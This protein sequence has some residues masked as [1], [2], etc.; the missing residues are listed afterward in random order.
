[1]LQLPSQQVRSKCIISL[2]NFA[3]FIQTQ[4]HSNQ[5]AIQLKAGDLKCYS[6]VYGR[7]NNG[8]LM[9]SITQS[10]EPMKMLSYT[11]KENSGYRRSQDL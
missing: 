6:L 5:V 2:E 10:P 11:A 4:D 1:M 8:P 3:V 7:Q 9:M